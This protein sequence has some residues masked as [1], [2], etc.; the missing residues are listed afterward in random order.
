MIRTIA[1][2]LSLCSSCYGD[3]PFAELRT[4]S[5]PAIVPSY[6]PWK[7]G[8][9]VFKAAGDESRYGQH[10]T[11]FFLNDTT[12]IMAGHGINEKFD[13]RTINVLGERP[14]SYF[15][16]SMY[17]KKAEEQKDYTSWWKYDATIVVFRD[18]AAKRIG[19]TSRDFLEFSAV[20]FEQAS[21]D[22]RVLGYVGQTVWKKEYDISPFREGKNRIDLTKNGQLFFLGFDHETKG[23][24]NILPAYGTSGGP[25]L[26]DK[27]G[28]VVGIFSWF[29]EE[30]DPRSEMDMK[31]PEGEKWAVYARTDSPETKTLAYAATHCDQVFG[32]QKKFCANPKGFAGQEKSTLFDYGFEIDSD[33]KG[34]G[35]RVS[36]KRYG[37]C[38]ISFL[39]KRENVVI[40]NFDSKEAF[41]RYLNSPGLNDRFNLKLEIEGGKEEVF[42]RESCMPQVIFQATP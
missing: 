27:S 12:A 20:P 37:N 31:V 4:N 2:L 30:E 16:Y 6:I 40:R 42:E 21:K 3:L 39:K 10:Q 38:A 29:A 13:W 15:K 8:L 36:A 24:E 35:I 1:L 34:P 14:I 33:Y 19:I 11:F 7:E 23:S 5:F 32:L 17:R 26:D 25:L 9:P 18:G 22:V 41:L 28:K